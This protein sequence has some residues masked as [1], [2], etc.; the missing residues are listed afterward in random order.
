MLTFRIDRGRERENV[1]KSC[2]LFEVTNSVAE[3]PT[4]PHNALK[5]QMIWQLVY[6]TVI[7]QMG[8][9]VCVGVG[10]R[11]REKEL[12][13]LKLSLVMADIHQVI[14]S[15]SY[16]SHRPS[17]KVQRSNATG[18]AERTYGTGAL[19]QGFPAHVRKFAL[20]FG[21]YFKHGIPVGNQCL[22]SSFLTLVRLATATSFLRLSRPTLRA[23]NNNARH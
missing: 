6:S 3:L 16:D 12:S 20:R 11:G 15:P 8:V 14:Q 18:R 13:V 7:K 21:G 9:C 17:C 23:I 19:F 22:S 2:A 10:G 1:L 4:V 5:R